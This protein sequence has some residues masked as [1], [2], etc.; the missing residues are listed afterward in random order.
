MGCGLRVLKSSV[1]YWTAEG[2]AMRVLIDSHT[3]LSPLSRLPGRVADR[4]KARLPFPNPA[5]QEAEKS[6]YW[7]GDIH[8]Q[9][10][11]YQ[12]EGDALI[13]PRGASPGN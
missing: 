1:M 11:G 4:I 13:V 9:I 12:L 5:H 3:N 6:G 7:T 8:Q 10:T 2:E